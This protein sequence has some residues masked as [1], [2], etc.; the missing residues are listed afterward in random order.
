MFLQAESV[1]ESRADDGTA[2]GDGSGG[3]AYY[4]GGPLERGAVY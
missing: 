4:L 1:P 3:E 2:V